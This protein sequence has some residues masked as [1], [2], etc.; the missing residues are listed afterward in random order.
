MKLKLALAAG[1]AAAMLL[2]AGVG[3]A[4]TSSNGM[5]S[6]LSIEVLYN[7]RKIVFDTKPKMIDGTVLVPIRF[8]VD[9]LNGKI[10]LQGKSVTVTKGSKTIK[11]TIGSKATAINGKSVTLLQP[12]IAEGGRT[13]VPLRVISEGLGVPVEWDSVS[14]FV[15]IGNKDVP[16]LED[17]VKAVD[18]KPYASLFKGKQGELVINDGFSPRK[19][20]VR[21]IKEQ[22]FPL[23][24]ANNIYY[25]MDLA[26]DADGKEFTR[27]VTNDK[28][29]MGSSFYLLE[30][31]QS[32]KLR[33]EFSGGR[34]SIGDFRIHYNRI[35]SSNDE[36]NLGIKDY[37]SLSISELNYIGIYANSDSA[38]LVENYF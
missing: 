35:V 24:I 8:V 4:T 1:M 25:R 21:I 28:G 34:E 10:D 33:S 19:T 2:P 5:R 17:V 18:I 12:A 11:L 22:D 6:N 15:W 14:Q 31:G 3:N 23:I 30:T 36:F 32:A 9:K 16:K 37:K 26:H 20:K 27:S 7:A 29:V 13:L 38:I